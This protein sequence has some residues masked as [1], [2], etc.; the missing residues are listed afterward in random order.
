MVRRGALVEVMGRGGVWRRRV[1]G[2]QEGS[3][4]GMRRWADG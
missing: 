4:W 2:R 3:G 1:G